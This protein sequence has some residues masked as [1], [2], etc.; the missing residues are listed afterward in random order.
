[1]ST[2]PI[3]DSGPR[4]GVMCKR[5][6]RIFEASFSVDDVRLAGHPV[7]HPKLCVPLPTLAR[8][9]RDARVRK[10]VRP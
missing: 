5:C 9:M 7:G 6:G 10:T 8:E 4:K 3:F 1:M 2:S